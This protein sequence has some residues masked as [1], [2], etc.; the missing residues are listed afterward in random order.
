MT[1]ET[2]G[3]KTETKRGEKNKVDSDNERYVTPNPINASFWSEI[4]L[5]SK[6]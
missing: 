1:R 4:K 3:L 2:L 6:F 5:V